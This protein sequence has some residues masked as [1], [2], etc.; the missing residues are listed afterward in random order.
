MLL[1][2]SSCSITNQVV[3]ESG[4]VIRLGV[5]ISPF[6]LGNPKRRLS[7]ALVDRAGLVAQ[8]VQY[9]ELSEQS[10]CLSN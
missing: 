10:L 9:I 4:S 2:D 6:S 5:L 3:N 7:L 1:N 8:V